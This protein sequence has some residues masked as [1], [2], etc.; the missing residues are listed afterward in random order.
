MA[1]ETETT[2]TAAA[3]VQADAAQADAAQTGRTADGTVIDLRPAVDTIVYQL[4]RLGLSFDHKDDSCET[5][6]DYERGVVATFKDRTAT[7]TT[8]MD[9]DTKDSRTVQLADLEKVTEI[10]TWRSDGAAD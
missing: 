8:L 7:E 2:T 4:L 5:W 1:S 9:M 3:T 10:R 6:S